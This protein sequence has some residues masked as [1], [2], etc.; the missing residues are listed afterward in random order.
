[1]A[2]ISYGDVQR[3][4]HEALK[5]LLNDIQRLNGTINLVERQAERINDIEIFI[6]DIQR[7]VQIVSSGLT[8]GRQAGA[9]HR[10]AQMVNEIH[11]LKVR[12]A[13]IERF[14]QQ[15]GDYMQSRFAEEDEDRQ[16]RT[17]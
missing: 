3:A 6:R 9:D 11:E 1:M 14:A 4:V 17:A 7:N 15:M 16:Y 13:S 10:L 8:G 5:P 2:D 12:F